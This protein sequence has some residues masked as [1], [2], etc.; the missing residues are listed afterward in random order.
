M[1][2]WKFIDKPIN[3]KNAY[4]CCIYILD[5]GKRF[6]NG[7]DI[8]LDQSLF[9]MDYRIGDSGYS[10]DVNVSPILCKGKLI[11]LLSLICDVGLE[12]TRL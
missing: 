5:F 7:I 9:L 8:G 2:K 12:I 1:V 10:L 6:A 3:E 4:A 11:M